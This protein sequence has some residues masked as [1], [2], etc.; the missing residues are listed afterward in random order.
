MTYSPDMDQ[1]AAIHNAC[2]P[3]GWT[4]D[5]IRE[6]LAVKGT[7][8]FVAQD[9]SGFAL[10]RRIG[11]E[12]EVLTV[13]VLSGHRRRGVGRALVHAFRAWSELQG[14]GSIFLEVSERNEAARKLYEHNGFSI[15]SRRREYYRGEDGSHEHA[16]VMRA[17]VE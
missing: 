4:A 12:A 3:R 5:A 9:G 13:C 14:A 16:L 10:L 15:I 1:I 7:V 8:A 11:D 6:M 17:I 2:F